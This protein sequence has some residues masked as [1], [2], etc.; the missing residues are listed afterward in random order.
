MHPTLIFGIIWHSWPIINL[1]KHWFDRT[2]FLSAYAGFR[3]IQR[4]AQEM[5]KSPG[6]RPF[7]EVRLCLH[8][9]LCSILAKITN[10]WWW[11]AS[12]QITYCNLG[13]PQALG[14]RPITFFREVITLNH[15]LQKKNL[16]WEALLSYASNIIICL[17]VLSLW[18]RKS[19]V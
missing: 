9:Y 18:D 12:L 14:Q 4:L 15:T 5:E 11:V 10:R 6:S 7:P 2:S 1:Q 13:N 8:I 3:V 17:Q 16:I 19:V